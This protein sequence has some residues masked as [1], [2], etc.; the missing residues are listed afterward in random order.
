[1]FKIGAYPQVY[2]KR[3]QSYKLFIRVSGLPARLSCPLHGKF[4]GAQLALHGPQTVH[5]T[6]EY[7]IDNPCGKSR[8]FFPVKD[9]GFVHRKPRAPK[10]GV[11]ITNPSK[12]A[13]FLFLG[14]PCFPRGVASQ[15]YQVV[16]RT[17][18]YCST[19][20]FSKD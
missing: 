14:R 13:S 1:M 15:A 6:E 8:Y 9:A 3:F 10:N 4:S 19:D 7:P 18:L 16:F 12:S 20:P 5:I 11:S 17:C 2:K